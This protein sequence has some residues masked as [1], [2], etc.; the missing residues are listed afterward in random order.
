MDRELLGDLDDGAVV[1]ETSPLGRVAN[2]MREVE[3]RINSTDSGEETQSLQAKI[4]AELDELLKQKQQQCNQAQSGQQSQ[5]NSQQSRRETPNPQS[6]QPQQSEQ[7]Q[8]AAANQPEQAG[9]KP[10]RDSQEGV[11][12]AD[13]AKP[14]LSDELADR[15]RA[16]WGHLP[17]HQRERMVQAFKEKYLQQYEELIKQY[18]TRL[19]EQKR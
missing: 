1:D 13:G 8:Q 10:A 7:P 16:I 3:N 2:K 6:Q 14:E 5:S 15:I 12:E 19:A 18:Y 9:N 17:E 4:L 11:R